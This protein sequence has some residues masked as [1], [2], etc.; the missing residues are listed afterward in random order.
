MP[1][2]RIGRI[3]AAEAVLVGENEIEVPAVTQRP[4]GDQTIDGLQIVGFDPEAT[5]V[6]LFYRNIFTAT[7]P[8]VSSDPLAP[9][10][11][12][13]YRTRPG[14]RRP[15]PSGLRIAP[16]LDDALAA[17]PGEFV[18]VPHGD[19]WPACS[20]VLQVGIGKVALVDHAIASTVSG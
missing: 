13:K 7:A 2:L 12:G 9:S 6:P 16:C 20:R 17:L 1:N 14:W 4:I 5:V 8:N 3:V 15:L 18:I 10:R 19:E 11:V